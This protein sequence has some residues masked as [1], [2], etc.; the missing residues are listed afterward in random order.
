[1]MIINKTAG[2]SLL[3][4][5]ALA[6]SGCVAQEAG[7]LP[8]PDKP[9]ISEKAAGKEQTVMAD[10][11]TL[12]EVR[13]AA[14]PDI[15]KY[16]DDNITAMSPGNAAKML[17]MLE[18]VQQERLPEFQSKFD[19]E[20]VQQT[21]IKNYHSGYAAIVDEPVA[22][23]LKET[24]ASG[25][26]VE[27]AEGMFFPIIDYARYK[28]YRSAVTEDIAAYIDIM[29]IESA[30]VPAKDAALVI[31]WDEVLQRALM[32]ERFIR[33]YG[34]SAKVEDIRQ[35]LKNYAA[36]ALYGANNTPLFSY[37]TKQ[38]MPKAEKTYLAAAFD[39]GNGRFSQAMSGYIAILKEYDFKLTDEVQQYRNNAFREFAGQ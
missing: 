36:F 16:I 34:N 2:I 1:M 29:A 38:M 9:G 18:K 39:N 23:L 14:I 32:Q 28:K 30:K 8:E 31:S 35:L 25:Y 4:V 21:L 12:V 27:T 24:A 6:V 15:I 20:I 19:R 7:S 3:L 10:F 11:N 22:T 13:N 26:Q 37:T 17:I 33:D 5:F